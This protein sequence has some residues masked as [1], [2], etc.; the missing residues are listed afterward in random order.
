MLILPFDAAFSENEWRDWVNHG[1]RFGV[2][3]VPAE[4]G[5]APIMVETHFTLLEKEILIHLHHANSALPFLESGNPVSLAVFSDYAFVESQ[6]RAKDPA[7]PEQGV[8]TSYY[9]AVNFALKPTVVA[10]AQEIAEILQAHMAD[11]QPQGG[12]AQISADLAPY[13]PMMGAIRGVRLEILAVEAKFKY[14]DHKSVEFREHVAGKL[15][16]RNQGLDAG[17][18]KQQLRRLNQIGDWQ[19]FSKN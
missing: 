3:A 10:D 18:A 14:D 16:E 2:L 8:P 11:L 15:E 5:Q 9:A 17:A 4:A 6:W 19:T 1:S 12:Y 7:Q 13:G